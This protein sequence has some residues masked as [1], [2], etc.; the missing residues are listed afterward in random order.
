MQQGLDGTKID[1]Q[2]NKREDGCFGVGGGRKGEE[3]G[4]CFQTMIFLCFILIDPLDLEKNE[5]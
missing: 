4:G 2:E 3:R 1:R 5:I